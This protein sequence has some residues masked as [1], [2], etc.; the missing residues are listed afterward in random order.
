MSVKFFSTHL[1]P[2]LTK[3]LHQFLGDL[4]GTGSLICWPIVLS[5]GC[6]IGKVNSVYFLIIFVIIQHKES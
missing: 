2:T 4:V 3:Y 6:P 1:S 5:W